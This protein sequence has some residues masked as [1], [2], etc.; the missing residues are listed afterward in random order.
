MMRWVPRAIKR[1][2]ITVRATQSYYDLRNWKL[3]KVIFTAT[4]GRSG[5]TSLWKIFSAVP[6]CRAFHE[7]Y[8]ILN[9]EWLRT[10]SY[11]GIQE[12]DRYYQQIK[13]IYIRRNAVGA[14]YYFEA[15]HLFAKTFIRPA[16]LDFGSKLEVVHLVRPA[17]EV[18]VS[19]Y[20]LRDWPG[21]EDGNTWWLDYRAPANRIKISELLDS[22]KEFS[23]P[24][25]KALWYWYEMEARIAHW[26]KVFPETKFH[27]FETRWI[28]EPERVMELLDNLRVTYDATKLSQVV[29]VKANDIVKRKGKDIFDLELACTMHERFQE[30]LREKNFLH[31]SGSLG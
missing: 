22:D 23:H 25:Y 27:Y 28:N 5:T 29:G 31:H 18:A 9:Q 16:I 8:P 17:L 4:T 2:A 7:P 12:V 26:K 10:A 21:T 15:N 11:G 1:N 14:R 19:I 24:F 30:M 6:G 13:S 20:R 3:N